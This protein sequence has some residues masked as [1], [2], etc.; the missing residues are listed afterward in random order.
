MSNGVVLV[1]QNNGKTDYVKQA[2]ALACSILAHNPNTNISLVTNDTVSHS[3]KKVFD[4]I[5]DI[6]WDDRAIHD[7][8]KIQN[9]W[10]VY[11]ITPYRNTV[12]LDV[13]MLVL[14]N[15]DYIFNGFD[16]Y[17][18]AFTGNVYTYRKEIV[19]NDYY[20]KT[21]TANQLPNLYSGVYQFSKCPETKQF[22][23]LLDI[24]MQNWE[25]FYKKYA[26][27]KM[28][29]FNSYDLSAAIAIKILGKEASF[30][31]PNLEF[32]HMKPY[33]QNLQKI[34]VP[35]KWTN[36]FSIDFSD[37]GLYVQGYKQQGIFHYVEDSFLTDDIFKYLEEKI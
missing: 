32:V 15:I 24:I 22:F 27:S 11:H 4:K 34:N 35:Q 37:S 10:K 17:D 5:L 25:I 8:W 9:R 18:L 14:E 1:A 7:E 3:Y 26:P 19:T 30:S 28:Q 21:F 16:L 33:I 23:V 36:G 20:R 31:N 6:P 13:D 12:V 2:Y 29:N